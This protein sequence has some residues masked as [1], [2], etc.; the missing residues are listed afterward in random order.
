M[1]KI[2]EVNVR[3]FKL[4]DNFISQYKERE[5][6]WGPVGY[7]TFKRTYARRLNEFTEG[8]EGTEAAAHA[9]ARLL[10]SRDNGNQLASVGRMAGPH[11]WAVHRPSPAHA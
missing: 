7:I 2:S 3:K 1:F 5:V 8:A 6:P 9:W 4:S 10:I 11:V